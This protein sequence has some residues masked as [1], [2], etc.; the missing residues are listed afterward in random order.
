MTPIAATATDHPPAQVSTPTMGD[1][2]R[3]VESIAP[4]APVA[5]LLALFH[6]QEDLL[7]VPLL[8]GRK[9]Y[10]GMVSRRAFMS[11]MTRAFV[12]EVYAKRPVSELIK[13]M[14]EMAAPPVSPAPEERID[15]VLVEYLARD[16]GMFYDALPV[17]AGDSLLGVVSIA[18]MMLSL[19]ES[20]NQLL[21]AVQSLGARLNREVALAAQLQRQLLPA[22]DIDLPGVRGLA[23]LLTSSEVGGDYYD[24]YTVDG[25]YAVLLVGD[26]SGHG[27]AA[28]TLVSAVKAGVNI[29]AAEGERVPERILARL[30]RTL[31]NTAQQTLYMTMFAACLDTLTGELAYANAGHQFPY[32][33]RAML[34]T[35]EMLD[36]GGLPLGKSEQAEYPPAS[37]E[38][39]LGDRLF[40]YTDGIVEELNPA[41]EP[42]GYER[43]EG[44]L[45]AHA[46]G[47]FT[48]LRDTLL[49][50]LTQHAG[51]TTFEDDVTL[52]S[53][54][55]VERPTQPADH[56]T[57]S[58]EE[59][60]SPPEQGLVRLPDA[61]YRAKNEPISPYVSRQALVFVAEPAFADLLPRFSQDGVRRVLPRHQAIIQRLGWDSLINQHQVGAHHADLAAL[62]PRTGTVWRE[63]RLDHSDDKAFVMEEGAAFLEES[64]VGPEHLDAAL[65]AID[66]LL[67]NGL[68]AAP[69]NG[70][71]DHLH[72]KGERRRLSHDENLSLH[73]GIGQGVLG[74]SVVDSWGTLTPAVFLHRLARHIEGEGL[75][76]GRGGAGFYLLWRLSDYLQL[77]VLP[78]RQ[79]QATVLF[80]LTRPLNTEADSGFQ[81]L[82]HSEVHEAIRHEPSLPDY[83]ASAVG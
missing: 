38:L 55:Y 21:N 47:E 4:D 43:L 66:E 22:P 49:D 61:W 54:E 74:L 1:L 52:F 53:V 16:P 6:K 81:F 31:L 78:H 56:G 17:V 62:L 67:E 33:Y 24:R 39:D 13:A 30:N 79:T 59:F 7:A 32:L 44:L 63:L 80:D 19:S 50:A 8:G 68:Y 65:L 46:E 69:K 23:T 40:L 25:R 48:A 71:G 75:I 14:P 37:T 58:A 28:G 27:V 2:A 36:A 60:P 29:L 18:D 15:R 82:F 72:A 35:L 77:R 34:G 26:V 42:F 10:L 9:R 3:P 83:P 64:G 11:F 20:Q 73:I 12:H 41:E 5:T 57:A 76:A 45:Q 51:R 70:R